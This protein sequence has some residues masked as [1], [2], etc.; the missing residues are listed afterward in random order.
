M[1]PFA[2]PPLEGRPSPAWLRR[3][4]GLASLAALPPR[5]LPGWRDVLVETD[6][7]ERWRILPTGPQLPKTAK[8]EK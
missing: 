5:A 2:P 3:Q 1:E 6:A 8:F 7:A 4:K